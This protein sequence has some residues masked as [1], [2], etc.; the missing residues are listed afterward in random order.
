M[1]KSKAHLFGATSLLWLL[2]VTP[3]LAQMSEGAVAYGPYNAVFLH[4][5]TGLSKTLAAGDV[6][7]DPG[8][9][10]SIY[11]WVRVTR[12]IIGNTEIA[13]IGNP[14]LAGS[15]GLGTQDGKLAVY[16]GCNPVVRSDVALTPGSWHLVAA[17]FTEEEAH[18]FVDGA[19]VG[20][21]AAANGALAPLLSLAPVTSCVSE[22]KH[23]GGE[24]GGLTLLRR[25]LAS[26]ELAQMY[27]TPPDF[28][29]VEFA[30]GS[31]RWPV[32]TRG[33]AGMSSPQD[34]STLPHSNAPPR[35]PVAQ[36]AM[37]GTEALTPGEPGQWI[38]RGGWR[39]QPAP[40][41]SVAGETVSSGSYNASDW[42][43]AIV[44]G[45]VLTTM[46]SRGIYPDPDY[47]LNNM[48][49]PESLNKQDYWY[50]KEFPTPVIKDRQNLTLTFEGINYAA[51][52]WLNGK[53]LGEIR[54][55]FLRGTFDVSALLK[56]NGMNV[57]AVRISPPPHPGIPHEQS[58]KGGPGE[59][60]GIMVLDGPTFAATEGWDWIPGV[61]DRDSGI[62]QDVTLTASG[63]VRVGDVQVVTTLPQHDSS[64]ADVEI[65]VPLTSRARSSVRGDVHISFDDVNV[66]KT[67]TVTG[68]ETEVRFA[69]SEYAQLKVKQP[70]L[71]WPNGYGEPALHMMKVWF[72]AGGRTLSEKQVRF[73]MR[74]ISYELS[75]LDAQGNL[76][77]VEFSPSI[78]KGEKVVSQ[79]HQALRQTSL[80]WVASLYPGA[81]SSPSLRA[82]TD[83]KTAPYLVIRV[84]GVRIACK[85]GNW[86][87][88]DY[89]K[90]VSREH[91]EPF[92]RL[93]RDAHLNMIRNWMGQD[94]EEIF[95]DLADEYGLL[96]WND[97][98]D[99]TQNYNLE[100]ADPALFLAN[101]K[102]TILR[103]RNHPSIAVWCG[104]NE[105]VPPPI[106]N[107]GLEK[108]VREVDGTRYYSASSN[109]VN[110]QNSG[111][112]S[113]KP[114]SK[115]F[116]TLDRGF[117]VEVG[118][119][120]MS[121]L[122]SFQHTIAPAD[123]WPV[124]DAWAYHDWH[125]SGNG[126]V[127][128]FMQEITTEFGQPTGLADFERKAQMLN[129]V[130]HRA[131]FEGF[132]AHLWAPNSGRML[133]MTQPAW[134]STMWQIFS[135]DYDTQ[136][137]FYG[138]KVGAEPVHVQMNL[139][140]L[141]AAI[142]NNTEKA[143][144]GATLAVHAVRGDGTTVFE[145]QENVSAPAQAV[146]TSYLVDIGLASAKDVVFVEMELKDG[147][148][149]VLS[150]NFYWYAADSET[151]RGLNKLP[152]VAVTTQPVAEASSAG[153]AHVS[154]ALENTGSA[155]AVAAKLTLLRASDG[156]RILPAYF[157]DNYVSLLPGE[158]RVIEI[159]YPAAQAS[160]AAVAIRG[161]NILPAKAEIQAK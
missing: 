56:K 39:L 30:D 69:P 11:G 29:Q 156:E 35:A 34:P 116:T 41:V 105:G 73:G 129:Y 58:I 147:Q 106:I 26:S 4:D 132:N 153:E 25:A 51:S 143:I 63:A 100:P 80:G 20:H 60:G 142:V 72:T 139:P 155:V 134:P 8:A 28:G 77:R 114:P 31:I 24:L 6:L 9:Q 82:L 65:A 152:Q 7:L 32:Q 64:E 98:W 48:A 84:N 55:A 53:Y 88:D 36:P 111:P 148:G 151:Y 145:H 104:R 109:Q 99:S 133:W 150:R 112:Y 43:E 2:L 13:V 44:P 127:A 46:V 10:W 119:P 66:T 61:R 40:K 94:T 130:D 125:Q 18:L 122:E 49:I 21:G 5:G 101:A 16:A 37:S 140:D 157:S 74:E 93:H 131:I 97:F 154:V 107:E 27:S 86:G 62:W 113:Y 22:G 110:L 68:N 79:S 115:F 42:M 117:S 15:R 118:T 120:S 135:S 128:P 59:N 102:D 149:A 76:K 17:T 137:S 90:R 141:H 23:F 33:Q 95:Y 123:Q 57:L 1:A 161:W 89:R 108:L 78:T 45:T 96:V 158:K 54:G 50:R 138:V 124:S 38:L 144:A 121:T 81:E 47:G 70:K 14:E 3:L 91:L 160:P 136:A 87:M 103:F 67:V 71:W 52:V 75:L 126:D 92:F 19:E 85:G 12:Q 83:L 159:S 146:T